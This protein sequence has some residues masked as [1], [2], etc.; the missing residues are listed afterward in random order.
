M[1]SSTHGTGWAFHEAAGRRRAEIQYVP[2][3]GPQPKPEACMNPPGGID[4]CLSFINSQFQPSAKL[5]SLPDKGAG[6]C[7]ITISRQSGCGA[8]VIAEKLAA[9]LQSHTPEGRPPWT[10][11][12]RNLVEKVLEDHRLPERFARFMPEDRVL[13]ID[14][15]MNELFGVHPSSWTLV[16]QTSETILRLVELG[17]VIV[18]GR[19]ANVVTAKLPHVLHVR[20]VSSLER[21][22]AQMLRFENLNRREATDRIQREDLGR[23]R[24]LRKHFNR[25]INDPLLYHL[26][27]NTDLVTLDDAARL[28][29]DLAV[30]RTFIQGKQA[31]AAT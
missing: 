22:I 4:Q 19:G 11:F 13:E 23:E 21:R 18:L 2:R 27:I 9:C 29:A 7:A 20:I 8:H 17:N 3:V 31:A 15:I 26:V 1:G 30:N 12:D 28:I 25:D 10:V 24:Y 14:D 5:E 16:E 6:R